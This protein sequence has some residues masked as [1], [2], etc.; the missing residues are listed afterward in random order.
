MLITPQ[1]DLEDRWQ[2]MPRIPSSFPTQNK[3]EDE[4]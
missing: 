3:I 4:M 2:Q 1:P